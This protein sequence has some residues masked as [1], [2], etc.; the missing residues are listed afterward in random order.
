MPKCRGR[1]T[2]RKKGKI[3]ESTRTYS[4]ARKKT[5]FRFALFRKRLTEL[6]IVPTLLSV[7][8]GL[9]HKLKNVFW[10]ENDEVET[11]RQ[12]DPRGTS[13]EFAYFRRKLFGLKFIRI[14]SFST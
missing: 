2:E 7:G 10:L 13:V 5:T 6:Y 3:I 1:I 9:Q 8:F 14:S 11:T 4:Q 12:T